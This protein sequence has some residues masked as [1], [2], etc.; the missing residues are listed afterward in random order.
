LERSPGAL[1]FIHPGIQLGK[2]LVC[3][4]AY[5]GAILAGIKRQQLP[6]FFQREAGGLGLTSASP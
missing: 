4:L 6:D 2:A 3:H 1:E 5:G